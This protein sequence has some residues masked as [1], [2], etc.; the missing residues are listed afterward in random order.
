MT[1]KMTS[2]EQR[3][4]CERRRIARM[5]PLIEH[6]MQVTSKTKA[7]LAARVRKHRIAHLGADRFSRPLGHDQE[8]RKFPAIGQ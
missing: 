8:N 3:P 4:H 6:A 1:I 5:M 2:G 7:D